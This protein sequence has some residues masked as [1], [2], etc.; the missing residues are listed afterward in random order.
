MQ[1]NGKPNGKPTESEETIGPKDFIRY[2]L[3]SMGM[4]SLVATV[5]WSYVQRRDAEL[6]AETAFTVEL[7]TILQ[8]K[9]ALRDAI[10]QV[11]ALRQEI[12]S[13]SSVSNQEK[14]KL[15][16]RANTINTGLRTVDSLI[17]AAVGEINRYRRG[18]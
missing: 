10:E 15:L 12:Q 3:L 6:R 2:A 13:L 18:R 14:L 4:L 17:D 1:T 11:A 7:Q 16:S 8:K 9:D 5:Y